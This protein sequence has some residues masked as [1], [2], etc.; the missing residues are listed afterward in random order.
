ME[1]QED[2]EWIVKIEGSKR[3]IERKNGE[4]MEIIADNDVI[5]AKKSLS[6]DHLR[7]FQ[8][9]INKTWYFD[10]K[11]LMKKYPLEKS[12]GRQR[13]FS[14]MK[15]DKKQAIIITKVGQKARI[16]FPFGE[17]GRYF[18]KPASPFYW[19]WMNWTGELS[20][21]SSSSLEISTVKIGE[22]DLQDL[23]LKCASCSSNTVILDHK[24]KTKQ[25]NI[26]NL[27]RVMINGF[28]KAEKWVKKLEEI[29]SIQNQNL[30]DILKVYVSSF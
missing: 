6:L 24:N 17:A 21:P 5:F 27:S 23:G 16:F 4:R 3:F 22:I 29:F 30:S 28:K 10:M 14:D 9:R 25:C 1:E 12:E 2:D 7:P 18:C 20:N 26:I 15:F 8:M 19:S 11:G 13:C